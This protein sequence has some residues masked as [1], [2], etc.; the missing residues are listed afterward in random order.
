MKDDE[1]LNSMKDLKEEYVRYFEDVPIQKYAAMYVGR[2][3]DTIIRWRNQDAVFADRI[4]QSKANWVRKMLIKTKAEFAL[5]RLEKKVFGADAK[6]EN[7]NYE[8]RVHFVGSDPE[9]DDIE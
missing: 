4:L 2:D 5:E 6:I 3:E 7:D 1:N 9:E 8:I